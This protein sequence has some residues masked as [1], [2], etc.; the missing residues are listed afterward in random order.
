VSSPLNAEDLFHTGFL[1]NDLDAE[2]TR[3]AA[4]AGHEWTIPLETDL[5]LWTTSGEMRLPIKFVYSLTAPYVELVQA[6][7]GTPWVSAPGNAAHHIGYWVDDI[8][9]TAKRLEQHGF[10]L[11]CYGLA[12]G[13]G[14]SMFAFLINQTGI[15]IEIVQRAVMSDFLAMLQGLTPPAF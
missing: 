10:E 6:L 13:V 1:V 4:A 5:P 2:M 14:P 3:M 8:P 11:E 9:Q 15:R 7:P 12:D